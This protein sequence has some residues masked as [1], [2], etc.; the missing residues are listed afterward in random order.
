MNKQSK[1]CTKL[2]LIFLILLPLLISACGSDGD[3]KNLAKAVD[4]ESQRQ[5]R[6]QGGLEAFP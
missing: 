5:L 2:Q 6:G 1:T 4:L 3:S